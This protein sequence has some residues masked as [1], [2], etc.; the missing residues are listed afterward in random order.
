MSCKLKR[1]GDIL[2][3]VFGKYFCVDFV[4]KRLDAKRDYLLVKS[5]N[6]L[7][8]ERIKKKQRFV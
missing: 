5:Y 4:T 7:H 3:A 6:I 8:K 2:V 1:D